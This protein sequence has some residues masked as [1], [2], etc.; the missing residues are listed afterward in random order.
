MKIWKVMPRVSLLLTKSFIKRLYAK[1]L[2]RDFHPLFLLYHFSFLLMII[3]IPLTI[4]VVRSFNP[5]Y[6]LSLQTFIAFV[7]LSISSFQSLFFAMWMD[8]MDNE[9][10]IK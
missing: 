3:N 5:S 6:Q 4:K 10:L 8:M 2:F 9:R 7:F 1:Y